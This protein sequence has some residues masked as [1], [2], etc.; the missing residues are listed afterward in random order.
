MLHHTIES[1]QSIVTDYPEMLNEIP[2]S[3]WMHKP[4]PAKW[5]KKEILGHLIDSAQNNIRRFVV[6]QYEENP[7]IVY[8]QD[9]W[10]RISGYEN[11]NTKDLIALWILLNKHIC[12][13]LSNMPAGMEKRTAKTNEL[14]SIEW[15]A[16][17]YNK[18]LLHHLHQVL[19]R[20]PVAY[21]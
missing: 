1:L 5:S 10:V 2:E 12:I 4:N 9:D 21:P 14:H 20:N 17:D 19:D 6:A 7:H 11:Y 18:H 13:I 16:E 8:A 15:I 3:K